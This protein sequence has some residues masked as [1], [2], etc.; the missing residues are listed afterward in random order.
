M[1]LLFSCSSN[2]DDGDDQSLNDPVGT[3][4][5]TSAKTSAAIDSDADGVFDNTELMDVINCSP[6]IILNADNTLVTDSFYIEQ[7]FINNVIN[8][9][10]CQLYT[11]YSGT[12]TITDGSVIFTSNEGNAIWTISGNTITRIETGNY[13]Y[14]SPTDIGEVTI[15]YTYTK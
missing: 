4:T 9:I 13:F 14:I 10:S 2:D 8:P 5:L 7:N 11:A 6:K 3:Y 1:T 15:T 12:Y